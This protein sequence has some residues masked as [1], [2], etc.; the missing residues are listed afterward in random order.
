M[1]NDIDSLS[2]T[3]WRCQYHIVFA[4]KYRRQMIYGKYKTEIGKNITRDMCKKWDK[5]NRSK[6]MSRSHTYVSEYTAEN[7]CIKIY[8]N[9]KG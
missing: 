1:S 4:P 2:H 5:D 8:G 6:C 3:K 9:I 7:E